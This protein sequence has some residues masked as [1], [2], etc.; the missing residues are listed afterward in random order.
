MKKK[1]VLLITIVVSAAMGIGIGLVLRN[2]TVTPYGLGNH[3]G[4]HYLN[5]RGV[6][7]FYAVWIEH[8]CYSTDGR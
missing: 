7:V 1:M 5:D 3:F 8:N 4:R 6:A 2:N